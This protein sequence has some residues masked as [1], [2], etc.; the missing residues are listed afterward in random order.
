VL[1]YSET[2]EGAPAVGPSNTGLQE[3][4]LRNWAQITQPVGRLRAS[5]GPQLDESTKAEHNQV[6]PRCGCWQKSGAERRFHLYEF[7][8][9][10]VMIISFRAVLLRAA[11]HRSQPFP[12]S[13]ILGASLLFC[14]SICP[15]PQTRVAARSQCRGRRC[16]RAC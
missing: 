2:I 6:E 11:L 15:S 12:L 16:C 4:G 13:V 1:L 8:V 10:H 5:A 9:R 7:V 14:S 3:R